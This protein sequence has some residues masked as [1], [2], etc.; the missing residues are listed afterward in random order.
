MDYK[1]EIDDIIDALNDILSAD[2]EAIQ[3]LVET[4]IPC[5]DKLADHPTVQVQA[6]EK[7]CK[8]GLL[9]V[10]NG[11]LGADD[12][13]LGYICA[14][15]DESGKLTEFKITPG[16]VRTKRYCKRTYGAFGSMTTVKCQNECKP[17]LDVCSKHAKEVR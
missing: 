12:N 6:D 11:V 8:V 4:Y 17:G 1:V 2:P 14:C 16:C 9:G 13:G 10:L 3:K 5:N 7:G 15:F